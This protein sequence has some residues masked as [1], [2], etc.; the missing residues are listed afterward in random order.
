MSPFFENNVVHRGGLVLV[1]LVAACGRASGP[2][3][4]A[5]SGSAPGVTITHEGVD[6]QLRNEEHG[7]DAV[8]DARAD[9]VYR[10][11]P[12][13]YQ[14]MGLEPGIIQTAQRRFGSVNV[15]GTRVAGEPM[16]ELI[17]CGPQGSG[18]A[19]LTRFRVMLQIVSKVTPV[20]DARS[21]VNTSVTGKAS[22]IDGTSTGSIDCVST[23]RLEQMIAG[24]LRLALQSGS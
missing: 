8:F 24:R 14:E 10:H 15:S 13:V 11:L 17:R 6:A 4:P 22:R 21:S 5:A 18:P 9:E 23:G 12:K 7:L 20:S 19:S 16:Y 3:Q 1:L 2:V